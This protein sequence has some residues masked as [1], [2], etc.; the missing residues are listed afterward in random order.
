MN[1]RKKKHEAGT[2]FCLAVADG[3]ETFMEYDE[4]E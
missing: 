4:Y 3:I 1:F 2:Y